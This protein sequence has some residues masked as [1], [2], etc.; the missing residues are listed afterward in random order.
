MSDRAVLFVDGNNWYHSLSAIGL[1]DLGRLDYS[2]ISRK[3]LG[4]R[5]WVATRYYIGQVQQRGGG[6]LYAEQRRFLDALR[7]DDSRISVHLG[8]LERRFLKSGAAVELRG[9]LASLPFR[10]QEGVFRDLMGIAKGHETVEVTVEKAVDV[11]LAVDM[12]KLAERDQLDAA[13][14]LS[15]DG[16]YTPVG[17]SLREA[18]KKVYAVSPSYGVQLAGTVDAFIRVRADWF[19]DCYR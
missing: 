6:R 2:K 16:D 14:L 11:M 4:P 8:R 13:Y 3:L 15:A 18:G 10:I 1:A 7:S 12:V 9:Y 19:S 17:E 5:V